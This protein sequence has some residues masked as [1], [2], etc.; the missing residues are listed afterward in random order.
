MS[1]E[2]E[3]EYWQV[4]AGDTRRDYAALCLDLGVIL[5][6]PG[7][8]GPWTENRETDRQGHGPQKV[9]DLA[10]FCETMKSGD[11]VVLKL[12]FGTVYGLG[13]VAGPYDWNN[14]FGD[15]DGGR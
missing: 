13:I 8:H 15:I 1:E 10:R 14:H 5:N 6:G 11:R 12:G 2:V 9:S 4:A 7:V 3:R